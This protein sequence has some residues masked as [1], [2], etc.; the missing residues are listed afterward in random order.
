ML[1]FFVRRI[2]LV[3]PTLA[4]LLLLTFLLVRVVPNDPSAALAGE[5]ATLAQIEEIR[6]Q[7][8]FDRPLWQQFFIYVGQ[9]A[10]FDFGKS[11]YTN[12]PVAQ[13]IKQRLPAT[14]EL[15]FIALALGAGLGIPLGVLAAI[16]HNRFAD[17]AIRVLTVGGLAV[18]SFW[19]A[20]MLQFLFAMELDL[21]PLR[22][23]LAVATDLPPLVTG[24]HLIDS[25]LAGRLDIFADTLRHLALPAFTLSIGAIA[26]ITRFTRSGVLETLQRDFVIYETA[27]GYPRPVLIGVYVLRNSVVAAIT[28]I[29]LLFGAL[30][31]GAVVVESIFDWPG[32]GTYAV[33]GILSADF[34]AVLAVTLL[35]GIIYAMVNILVDLVH[36][37][38]DPRVAEQL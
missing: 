1:R 13:D 25:L 23:R 4:G 32:I 38:V 5:N 28:Q 36:A 19:F 34:K 3:V 18:A 22:G 37:L 21:L 24:F 26:T 2:L 9:V 6:R 11:I 10:A 15:T 27:V 14:L 31:G 8:G 20:I 16:S 12:A 33:R 17:Y 29:G 7:Y 30:I 35:V